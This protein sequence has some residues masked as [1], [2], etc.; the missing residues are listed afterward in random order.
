MADFKEAM[1]FL[2]TLEFSSPSDILHKNP[3]EKDITFYGIYKYAHPS[4]AGW[5]KVLKAIDKMGNL[6]KASVLLS[7]DSELKELVYK[8]YKSEFWNAMKL[9]YIED[10]IKANEMFVFGVNAGQANAIKAAQKLVGVSVDGIIGEKTI[11]AINAYD[12]LAFDLGYDRLEI[13]YYQ[14]LIERDPSL[15]INRQGWIRRAKAV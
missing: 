11:R 6:E 3:K 7:K 15:A 4:W 9:D 1:A 5:D 2:E 10:N 8:F 14:S 13:A 12:T